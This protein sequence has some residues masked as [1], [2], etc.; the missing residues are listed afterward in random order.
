M[1]TKER[2]LRA[3]IAKIVDPPGYFVTYPLSEADAEL[4]DLTVDTSITVRKKEDHKAIETGQIVYLS[5]IVK[6]DKG[7][8]AQELS[9]ISVS[10]RS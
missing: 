2:L 8:R 10:A 1:S 5:E 9:I 6:H 7:W 3:R 4:F